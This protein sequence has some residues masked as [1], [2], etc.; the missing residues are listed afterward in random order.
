MN[1]V[2]NCQLSRA[3]QAEEELISLGWV[4]FEWAQ[5]QR[6]VGPDHYDDNGDDDDDNDKRDGHHHQMKKEGMNT[7]E[8]LLWLPDWY[9]LCPPA[10]TAIIDSYYK[11]VMMILFVTGISSH[12]EN[13]IF[14]MM[15]CNWRLLTVNW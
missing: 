7:T 14:A 5:G 8:T 12:F 6:L 3:Y 4:G 15:Q 1:K 9:W 11:I 10:I 13:I 2:K